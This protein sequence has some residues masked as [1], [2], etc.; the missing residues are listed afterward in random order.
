MRIFCLIL[1]LLFSAQ[2]LA[3]GLPLPSSDKS[4]SSEGMV[5]NK[6]ETDNFIVLSIDQ[7]FGSR[8][9][10][11]VEDIKSDLYRSWGI[12]DDPFPV[13]CKIVCVPD[14]A[15]LKKFFSL[16]F[17]KH[18]IKLDKQKEIAIWLDQ[19]RS[20]MLPALI[21][22]IYLH[23]RPVF[24][25]KGIPTIMLSSPSKISEIIR[26]SPEFSSSVLY[27]SEDQA[28]K[29]LP[30]DSSIEA[31]SVVACLFF[32]KEFG[33]VLFSRVL[34]DKN[35][36]PETVCGFADRKSLEAS[37]NRYFE[38]LKSDLKYGKTPD[39]YLAH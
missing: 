6:W 2:V 23:D 15:V 5:W 27:F 39:S 21:A 9:K 11:S 7:D 10:S 16:D 17:P 22:S 26:N 32:K 12:K 25:Q 8:L 36:T 14:P 37:L 35:N 38:N 20:Q 13:K 18:E 19:T 1:S 34:D 4:F 31:H 30:K 28:R 29:A 24:L 33:R 3:D